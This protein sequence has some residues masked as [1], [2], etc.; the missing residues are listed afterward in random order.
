MANQVQHQ[1][2]TV[3]WPEYYA[4]GERLATRIH[5]SGWQFDQI[6]CIARG[7]MFIGDMLSRIFKKPLAVISASSYRGPDGK[8]KKQLVVSKEIA[9]TTDTLAKRVLLV[10]DLVD[11]GDSLWQVKCSVEEKYTGVEI[12]TAVLWYKSCSKIIPDYYGDD[13]VDEHTWIHQPFEGYDSKTPE[14]LGQ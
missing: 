12:K 2:L 4:T 1:T 6:L 9:M 11:S 3:T 14:L 10:D 8:Q 13:S 5:A 7:G